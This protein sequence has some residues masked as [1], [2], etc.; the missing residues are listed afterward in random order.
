MRPHKYSKV[1]CYGIYLAKIWLDGYMA[2]W[3][4][5]HPKGETE[6][7]FGSVY[8]CVKEFQTCRATL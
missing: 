7:Y 8:V 1:I 6:Q 5:L 2:K 3:L 4:L